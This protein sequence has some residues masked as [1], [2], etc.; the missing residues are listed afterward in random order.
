MECRQPVGAHKGSMFPKRV[1][2]ILIVRLS[3]RG[4]L[5]FASPLARALR[6]RFPDAHIAWLAEART[7]DVVSH[8]PHL[9]EVIVWNRGEWKQL[10]RSFQWRRLAREVGEFVRS[11]QSRRFDV[12]IDAQGLLR[13]GLVTYVSG[14]G[15]RFGLGSREGSGLLMTRVL[16]RG[17]EDREI[18]SEYKFLAQQLGLNTT[19]F[20]IEI[21]RS[22][23]EMAFARG[24]V[25]DRGLGDG[26]VIACPFTTR[27]YKHWFEDRWSDLIT[28]MVDEL[29][30]PVVLLGGPD[31]RQAAESILGAIPAGAAEKVVDLVGK[32]RLGEAS[33]L[34]GLCDLLVGVDTGLSHMAHGYGR[35]TVLLF[36][37]NTPYLDPPLPTSQILWAGLPCSPCRGRLTC[38]NRVDCMVAHEVP[39]V[40]AAVRH[41]LTLA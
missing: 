8:N 6:E 26:F 17:G 11:L 14:A 20:A 7:S 28:R 31:D 12:A 35:P 23:K 40:L 29:S 21:P 37:S 33:A 18:G 27:F 19:P 4:D 15:H 38:D 32:T 1:E 39:G 25:E 34:V 30:V 13:S 3:A 24:I 9:D 5:V 2:K 16:P 41:G 22:D 10:F 36:G